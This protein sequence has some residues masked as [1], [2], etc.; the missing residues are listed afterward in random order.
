MCINYTK[1]IVLQK[2][3]IGQPGNLVL[4]STT[5]WSTP[6][7]CKGTAITLRIKVEHVSAWVYTVGNLYQLPAPG[8][9]GYF[10]LA[11]IQHIL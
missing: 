4:K 5:F 8:A 2:E 11:P 10:C 1:T 7:Q 6:F 9:I 3:I